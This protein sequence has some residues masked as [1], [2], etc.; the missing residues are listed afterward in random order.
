[1]PAPASR[2]ILLASWTA[3]GVGLLFE[4]LQVGILKLGGLPF[5]AVAAA[6]AE[7]AQ[8]VCWSYLVC[9]SLAVGTAVARA[10]PRAMAGLGF[11]VAPLAFGAARSLHQGVMQL[12]SAGVA[13]GGPNLWLLAGIKAVEYAVLGFLVAVLVR[14]PGAALPGYLRAGLVVGVLF[15]GLLVWLMDR[16]APPPGFSA[17][18][19]VARS[20]NEVLFPVACA[21]LLWVTNTVARRT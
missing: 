5:P 18:T 16:A 6:V 20:V 11:V 15:G 8:K 17:P 4:A 12:L 21:S 19:L 1:M 9:V 3:V 14:R 7:T 2:T 10:S 13:S